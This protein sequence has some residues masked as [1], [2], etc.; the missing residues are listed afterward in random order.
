MHWSTEITISRWCCVCSALVIII[1]AVAAVV[2]V[3]VVVVALIVHHVQHPQ[4]YQHQQQINKNQANGGILNG[5]DTTSHLIRAPRPPIRNASSISTSCG[6]ASGGIS[7]SINSGVNTLIDQTP[8]NGS[9][10]SGV[11]STP[12]SKG[13]SHQH[14]GHMHT[15]GGATNMDNIALT[16]SATAGTS[17]PATSGGVHLLQQQ[18]PQAAIDEMRV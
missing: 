11:S 12:S 14:L 15:L 9:S 8:S 2:V 18:V 4:Q 5:L 7:T 17:A 1:V 3:V 6:S 16:T 13:H 10:S